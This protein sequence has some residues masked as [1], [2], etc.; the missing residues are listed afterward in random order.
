MDFKGMRM[1]K[2]SRKCTAA[3]CQ[4]LLRF[5]DCLTI[6]PVVSRSQSVF[7]SRFK[8]IQLLIAPWLSFLLIAALSVL[9]S[10]LSSSE[11]R[12]A[13]ER[14]LIQVRL[15]SPLIGL[16]S[17]GF[18]LH[19]LV[20]CSVRERYSSRSTMSQVAVLLG[21]TLLKHVPLYS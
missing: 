19:H 9:V 10:L 12:E 18:L 15:A 13:N 14:L 21:S 16:N 8:D 2:E 11:T 7:D 4:F 1:A 6:N 5:D 17:V 3:V 20:Q